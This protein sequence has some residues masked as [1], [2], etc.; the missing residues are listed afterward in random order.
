M[1]ERLK[2]R[3]LNE[4]EGAKV[5]ST[6]GATLGSTKGLRVGKRVGIMGASVGSEL[7]LKDVEKVVGEESHKRVVRS[8][9][10]DAV[11]DGKVELVGTVSITPQKNQDSEVTRRRKTRT[12]KKRLT[13]VPST[14]R[15]ENWNQN[16]SSIEHSAAS[17][18]REAMSPTVATGSVTAAAVGGAASI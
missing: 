5:G 14:M 13:E 3:E 2:E 6:E 10:A 11:S 4:V 12:I 18:K 16:H 17:T 8:R 9:R 7:G 15:P 1:T